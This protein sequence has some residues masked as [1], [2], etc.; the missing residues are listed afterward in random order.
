MHPNLGPTWKTPLRLII[1]LATRVVEAVA[2]TLHW[3]YT[4]VETVSVSILL[5]L[6]L[7]WFQ[8]LLL[9]KQQ[10][11]LIPVLLPLKT[12]VRTCFWARK[13]WSKSLLCQHFPGN[14]G[15][16]LPLSALRGLPLY[17]MLIGLWKLEQSRPWAPIVQSLI[18]HLENWNHNTTDFFLSGTKTYI[19][20]GVK[21]IL[22]T[23][24]ENYVL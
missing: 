10:Q 2:D 13:C 23:L 20:Q 22:M 7:K 4:S 1:S 21:S 18:S 14:L 24:E 16:V 5:S 6:S 17:K 9:N 11:F 3:R 8:L 12:K 19:R 15:T